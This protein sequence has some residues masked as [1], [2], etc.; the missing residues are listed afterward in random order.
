[1]VSNPLKKPFGS[2][3][4][5]DVKVWVKFENMKLKI[6]E[7]VRET[8]SLKLGKQTPTACYLHRSY[9]TALPETMEKIIFSLD[10]VIA[11]QI[12]WNILKIY[13][14]EPKL[15]FLYYPD[16]E[17]EAYPVLDA[18]LVIDLESLGQKFRSYKDVVNKPILHRKELFVAPSHSC[19]ALFS[20]ITKEGEE[21]GLYDNSSEIGFSQSWQFFLKQKGYELV[22]GRLFR[23]A[24][25][26]GD[27]VN[28][29]RTAISRYNLSAPFQAVEKIGLL[30]DEYSYMDYGC[31]LGDDLSILRHQGF[32]AAGWD[33]NHL[34]DG[35]L[36]SS[37]IVNLGFVI[38]VIEN[39]DE[40][41]EAL[42]Q[43][44]SLATQLLV[45]SAMIASEKH[46]LKFRP[47]GD[48]VLTSRNT[49]QKYFTQQE[50]GEYISEELNHPVVALGQGIYG[51]FKNPDLELKF[52]NNRYRQRTRKTSLRIRQSAKARRE[53][54]IKNNEDA[55]RDYWQQVL[56]S[57][58]LPTRKIQIE[59][60]ELLRVFG[61]VAKLNLVVIELF[62]EDE[63]SD[64]IRLARERLLLSFAMAKFNGR[65]VFKH[66]D[67]ETQQE[68]REHF[69][70]I[71]EL[72]A[73]V[74]QELSKLSD[75][76]LLK[77]LAEGW[78]SKGG[79]GYLDSD[80]SLTVHKH[81][82][83][84]LPL[85]L[86][87]YV[88]CAEKLFG[89]INSVD[90]LKIHF[91]SGK[92]SF[93]G[94]DGFGD[95]PIPMLRER[96]KVNLWTQKVDFFD[97]IDEFSPKPLY[98]KS[99]FL[100]DQFSDFV[101]QKAFDEKLKLFGYAPETPHFGPSRDELDRMLLKD[102]LTIKG[103]RYFSAKI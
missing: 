72:L 99:M 101:K 78:V 71:S 70:A 24:S 62:G 98:L 63:L 92:V 4:L 1:M 16:F 37:D 18:S 97:Y 10:S 35:E 46:V 83:D 64:A 11:R 89:E 93:M 42:N 22:D 51:V 94:Y 5:F 12:N 34:P 100:D 90:L 25:F 30:S 74:D 20:E 31:G 41:R 73:E 23:V 17:D 8:L 14:Q 2:V 27:V 60:K 7:A 56:E 61:T 81:F 67:S 47:F 33:P 13:K 87:L 49:F 40:R 32:V 9:L 68:V 6:A 82:F 55:L 29:E 102:G 26:S 48:G 15:S 28:R 50:L 19:F 79:A 38:N 85:T 69:H 21:A 52:W 96:I 88:S 80:R 3:Y 45:V 39:R 43:A 103:Y 84:S 57:G 36:R 76:G 95:T 65:V 66:L 75:V 54:D 91:Q 86:K 59:Q 53:A 44:F 58:K 77:T